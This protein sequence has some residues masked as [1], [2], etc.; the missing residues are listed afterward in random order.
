MSF[1]FTMNSSVSATSDVH[2]ACALE[3]CDFL[4]RSSGGGSCITSWENLLSRIAI[5]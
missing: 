2:W 3:E 5:L 1:S 4:P